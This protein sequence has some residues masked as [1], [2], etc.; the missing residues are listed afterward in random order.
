[1]LDYEHGPRSRVE[2]DELESAKKVADFIGVPH[3]GMKKVL[4]EDE[5]EA[6]EM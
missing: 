1:M 3:E 2:K 4:G 5:V 6:V